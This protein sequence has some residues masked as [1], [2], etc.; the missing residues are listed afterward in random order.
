MDLNLSPLSRRHFLR[1][2]GLTTGAVA[3][4]APLLNLN[5]MGNPK[6]HQGLRVI[7]VGAGIAGLCAAYELEQR[8]HEVVLL[9]ASDSHIGGRARTHHFGDGQYGELGAMRIP[10]THQ[11]TRHYVKQF[12]LT[13]RPFVQSNGEAFYFARG[14]KRRIKEES[15]MNQFYDLAPGET[16]K[17]P[18]DLWDQSVLTV[19]GALTDEEKADLRRVVFQ[20]ERMRT[21]DR[22]S[23]EEV[24]KQAGLSNEGIEFLCTLWAYETSLQ[25]GITTLLREELEETW[26]HDFDEIVGG[27]QEL[28]LAFAKNLKAKVRNGA[29]VSR[30]EQNAQT[31]KVAAI[32]RTKSGWERVEG[33]RLLCTVPLP[34]M[35]KIEFAPGLSGAKQRAVRQVTYDSSTKVLAKT[36]RRF[37]ESEDGIYGGGTY[38][39]LPTGITYYPADNATARDPRVTNNGGVMLASYTWGM[40]A[41]R[42]AAMPT[43]ERHDFTIDQL[44]K[45]HPQLQQNGMVEKVVS[46]SWDNNPLSGG[47]FCWWSPG[48]HE[49]LYRH[50]IAP[51]GNIFFA[52]EHAS[53]TH[54]WMQGAIESALRAVEEMIGAA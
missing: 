40:P 49:T 21:L 30:V 35:N 33:D 36:K 34:V 32:Y 12:G 2:M 5:A 52:G 45:I 8:G 23:L 27:T 6:G 22:L 42:M 43:A 13:L 4:I 11:L 9:E 53:L 50:V 17:S 7:V 31:G 47:A 51:E 37:W 44:S 14:Q 18:F 25:T 15:S 41:R 29:K 38:T 20:T 1:R 24:F 39:D 26:I 19:L 28:P 54:T 16:T 48:Q 3:T 46:W 10:A